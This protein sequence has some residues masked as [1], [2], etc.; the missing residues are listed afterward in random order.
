MFSS[1]LHIRSQTLFV[2][3]ITFCG[4][5]KIAT[6]E[7]STSQ[8][9]IF[10][11]LKRYNLLI[12]DF[13]CEGRVSFSFGYHLGRAL[14]MQRSSSARDPLYADLMLSGRPAFVPTHLFDGPKFFVPHEHCKRL[15]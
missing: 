9:I 1:F 3:A 7:Q 2:L 11:T 8:D 13:D 14:S 12:H 4:A 6:V 10:T 15:F 5:L